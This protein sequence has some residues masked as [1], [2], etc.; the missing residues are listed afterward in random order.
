VCPLETNWVA[1]GFA[2]PGEGQEEPEE[3]GSQ[4]NLERADPRGGTDR[5]K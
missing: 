3:A 4:S 5:P 2:A 1:A